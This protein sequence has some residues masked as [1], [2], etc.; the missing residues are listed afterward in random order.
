V[1][2]LR[3][4]SK[5]KPRPPP[6]RGGGGGSATPR[7]RAPR[8]RHAAGPRARRGRGA[9][10]TSASDPEILGEL[11]TSSDEGGSSR[12]RARRRPVAGAGANAAAAGAAA[13]AKARRPGGGAAASGAGGAAR[14]QTRTAAASTLALGLGAG[15]P[16][17]GSAAGGE[18]REWRGTL[19][20]G[21]R[22]VAPL[23]PAPQ[24]G[25]LHLCQRFNVPL[26]P[27]VPPHL[28][29]S[30]LLSPGPAPDGAPPPFA[31]DAPDGPAGAAA[32]VAAAAAADI[33]LSADMLAA[34]AGGPLSPIELALLQERVAAAAAIAREGLG[35]LGGGAGGALGAPA[36]GGG[37]RAPP[38]QAAPP[39]WGG[40]LLE[41]LGE[42]GVP[43]GLFTALDGG[44]GAP[45]PRRPPAG[46]AGG[47]RSA[48]GGGGAPA[49]GPAR[50]GSGGGFAA[51]RQLSVG[52]YTGSDGVPAPPP[53]AAPGAAP[54]PPTPAGA[55]PPLGRAGSGLS[56]LSPSPPPPRLAGTFWPVP[57]TCIGY[58]LVVCSLPPP[59]G[60]GAPD[61]FAPPLPLQA[62]PAAHARPAAAPAV[63]Q[64]QLSELIGAAAPGARPGIA[65]A[66]ARDMEMLQA[67]GGG[68][69]PWP[70]APGSAPSGRAP[71]GAGGLR[72]VPL[73][74]PQASS[75][76][77][78]SGSGF[79]YGSAGGSGVAASPYGP[80]SAARTPSQGLPPASVFDPWQATGGPGGPLLG[81][82]LFP[83]PAPL[84]PHP[85]DF[86][87]LA[88]GLPPAGATAAA[89][90][91]TPAAGPGA[92]ALPPPGSGGGGAGGLGEAGGVVADLGFGAFEASELFELLRRSEQALAGAGIPAATGTPVAAAAAGSG[93]GA[94]SGPLAPALAAAAG[95]MAAGSQPAGAQVSPFQLASQQAP[96]LLGCPATAGTGPP[97]V[98]ATVADG[99]APG[100]EGCE[101]ERGGGGGGGS[102]ALE[103]GSAAPPTAANGAGLGEAAGGQPALA[104]RAGAQQEVGRVTVLRRCAC[105]GPTGRP[106]ANAIAVG[107]ACANRSSAL[108]P[109]AACGGDGGGGGRGA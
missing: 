21:G 41:G 33:P 54:P 97:P 44:L 104:A 24:S 68:G 31:F 74:V 8:R 48:G 63:T 85:F 7:A 17:L 77:A 105:R 92:A 26:P 107:G 22:A 14:R 51:S 19:A 70:G 18:V 57:S 72:G 2:L 36:R 87:L 30:T 38:R 13:D 45:L 47:G 23:L 106:S 91:Q 82:P 32:V 56:A 4:E 93:P 37:G 60:A 80:P 64:R 81:P 3:E 55:P 89:P 95:G 84:P 100:G 71:A 53:P 59:A 29:P 94:A 78:R 6:M 25:G 52:A 20:S 43:G 69:A 46:G 103:A 35:G 96:V 99:S 65:N 88:P 49:A 16:L 109:P 42:L 101:P 12:K 67:L 108:A 66:Y 98:G 90:H 1:K 11:G 9:D 58:D 102:T 79:S 73:G 39:A 34:A 61:T 75:A 27:Q 15:S 10:T 40:G 86:S 83:A 5:R 28:L 50:G 62:S 76:L